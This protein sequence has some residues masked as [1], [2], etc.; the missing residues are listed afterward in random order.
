MTDLQV[1]TFVRGIVV[2]ILLIMFWNIFSQIVD[3]IKYLS[4]LSYSVE[5]IGIATGP[6]FFALSGLAGYAFK[7]LIKD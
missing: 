5:D 4:G 2:I 3:L 6:I 1:K 7:I